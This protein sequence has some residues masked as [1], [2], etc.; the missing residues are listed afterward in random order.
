MRRLATEH[1]FDDNPVVLREDEPSSIIAFTLRC[2]AISEYD[3]APDAGHSSRRYRDELRVADV[4]KS[5]DRAET[6]MPGEGQPGDRTSHWGFVDIEGVNADEV[7][8][9]PEVKHFRFRARRSGFSARLAHD[10][11]RV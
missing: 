6:F 3:A 8:R 11:R 1:I 9:K 4:A 2:P 7:L 10:V 5:A